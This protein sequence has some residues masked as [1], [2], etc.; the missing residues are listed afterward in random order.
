[1]AR[2]HSRRLW[3]LYE[4]IMSNADGVN[5]YIVKIDSSLKSRMIKDSK[6]YKDSL[7]R[8]IFNLKK[9]GNPGFWRV[10]DSIKGDKHTSSVGKT[11]QGSIINKTSS[12][13][14]DRI[15]LIRYTDENS[16]KTYV[17]LVGYQ[18]EHE[19]K[20]RWRTEVGEI[21]Q[22]HGGVVFDEEQSFDLVKESPSHDGELLEWGALY[23]VLK[24]GKIELTSSNQD[25]LFNEANITITMDQ[26][27]NIAKTPPLLIDGHAGTGKSIII[28]LRI[29]FHYSVHHKESKDQKD[30]PRL[31]VVAYNQRVLEMIER[32]ATYWMKRLIPHPEHYFQN[33]EYVPT[34]K[35]Y[36]SLVKEVEHNSIPDPMSLRS[37][38]KFVN[39]FKFQNEFFQ[40]IDDDSISAEQA[41][42]FIRGILKGHGHGWYGDK[43][44]QPLNIDD[45][46]SVSKGGTIARKFTHRMSRELIQ[47]LLGVFEKYETWRINKGYIDDLDLVR[48][49]FKALEASKPVDQPK[50]NHLVGS[51]DNVLIDEAQDLTSKEFELLTHLLSSNA[52]HIIVGG[53]PLQ[54][55][56]PTGFS[57]TSLESFLYEMMDEGEVKSATRM[58]VSHRLPKR[59]VDFSNVIIEA[60]SIVKN[61]VI[62]LMESAQKTNDGG[63][64]ARI[65]FDEE[66]PEDVQIIE[67]IMMDALN[68]NVGILLWA[69]DFSELDAISSDDVILGKHNLNPSLDAEDP[70]VFDV[71]SIESVKGLEYESIILYRFG[72]LDSQFNEMSEKS[73][74]PD[75]DGD[76]IDKNTYPILYHLNRLFIATSRAKKNVFIIDSKESLKNSWNDTIWK[77]HIQSDL[78]AESFKE[79]INTEPSLEKAETYFEKGKFDKDTNL[80]KKALASAMKCDENNEQRKLVINIRITLITLEI[81]YSPDDEKEF[82]ES[83]KMELIELYEKTDNLLQATLMRASLEQWDSIY[84]SCKDKKAPLLEML[85]NLSILDAKHGPDRKNN[86]AWILKNSKKFKELCRNP[87]VDQ[88]LG[89]IFRRRIRDSSRQLIRRLEVEDIKKLKQDFQFTNFQIMELLIPEWD[90]SS[91]PSSSNKNE[92]LEG[93]FKQTMEKLFGENLKDLTDKDAIK[94]DNILL[95]NPNITEEKADKLFK[96]LSDKGDKSGRKKH[97]KKLFSKKASFDPLDRIWGS[98]LKISETMDEPLATQKNRLEK[99]LTELENIRN[100]VFDSEKNIVSKHWKPAIQSFIRLSKN[101]NIEI[102]SEMEIFLKSGEIWSK[103]EPIINLTAHLKS[104]AERLIRSLYSSNKRIKG[105]L[106]KEFEEYLGPITKDIAKYCESQVVSL[107]EKL[108]ETWQR[109]FSYDSNAMVRSLEFMTEER[110]KKLNKAKA[111]VIKVELLF[112]VSGSFPLFYESKKPIESW[113]Y[114]SFTTSSREHAEVNITFRRWRSGLEMPDGFDVRSQFDIAQKFGDN[115]VIS[116]YSSEL[117]LG[118]KE[119]MEIG[120]ETLNFEMLRELEPAEILAAVDKLT[121][122]K[123]QE[124]AQWKNGKWFSS[125]SRSIKSEEYLPNLIQLDDVGKQLLYS[126]LVSNSF[127]QCFLAVYTHKFNGDAD[128]PQWIVNKI[129]VH[130]HSEFTKIAEIQASEAEFWQLVE[131]TDSFLDQIKPSKRKKSVT[132][133]LAILA[134]LETL[135]VLKKL[136]IPERREHLKLLGLEVKSTAKKSEI[137]ELLFNEPFMIKSFE[138][139]QEDFSGFEHIKDA[140]RTLLDK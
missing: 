5:T 104:I 117:E 26:F 135:F 131:R 81:A 79:H 34:L 39:F 82:T 19:R 67:E 123:I 80:L 114:K 132:V 62:E 21:C 51:F 87:S 76:D 50:D 38:R 11:K 29:A 126:V 96:S 12:T 65:E 73:L 44:D 108:F 115:T 78:T 24:Q 130:G 41:W 107:I 59:L 139:L 85:W 42:H 23:D 128:L 46:R 70:L 43:R 71:H 125:K 22:R 60:R 8:I 56:N 49:V 45:F 9:Y 30:I 116:A 77:S 2:D 121:P 91:S 6:D 14:G 90:D 69:R 32:Y 33:I 35:L 109:T 15:Y 101:P 105:L 119:K 18:L 4:E 72:D 84:S 140:A 100:A 28:A 88:P 110:S 55:I 64:V 36:H 66:N 113:I 47:K 13:Q 102:S 3:E 63:I 118:A 99:R 10:N 52:P 92:K 103:S 95:D 93:N 83:K 86:L 16:G 48:K 1:M 25:L 57:W 89:K 58:L 106:V 129:L 17:M 134:C 136:K 98:I 137:T 127:T 133:H 7:E 61:E 97:I 53:D 120:M 138:E 40:T 54:T 111:F 31:L 75:Y 68:S 20:K 124:D 94:F 74:R 37:A 122:K 112:K 27:R